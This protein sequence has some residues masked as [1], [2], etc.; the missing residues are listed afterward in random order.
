[1]GVLK[2]ENIAAGE[3][4]QAIC[5]AIL[6]SLYFITRIA[7][8]PKLKSLIKRF[9][10]GLF[11]LGAYGYFIWFGF[12]LGFGRTD[13]QTDQ[14]CEFE[15]SAPTEFKGVVHQFFVYCLNLIFWKVM[16]CV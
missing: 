3:T 13:G 5:W 11:G 16:G 7:K 8:L 10:V 14:L 6:T 1:M 4:P 15:R 2:K 12:L 9:F